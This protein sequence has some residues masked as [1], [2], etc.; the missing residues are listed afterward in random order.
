MPKAWIVR[1]TINGTNYAKA[2][3]DESTIAIGWGR[4]AAFEGLTKKEIKELLAKE[5]Y[6]L[7]AL[8]L[9]N[10]HNSV[11]NFVNEMALNDLVLIPNGEDIYFVEVIG[12]YSGTRG[13]PFNNWKDIQ[14]VRKVK[15]LAIKSR[16]DLSI[17]LRKKFKVRG[18]VVDVTLHY[19]EIEAIAFGKEYVPSEKTISKM[20]AVSFPLRPDVNVEFSVPSDMTDDEALKLSKFFETIYFKKADTE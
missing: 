4:Y 15:Q 19:E 16:T 1:A 5:P 13:Y 9:G 10:A 2:F 6:N 20:V 12:E 7:S 18:D 8:D 14:N 3:Y 11:N 17:E